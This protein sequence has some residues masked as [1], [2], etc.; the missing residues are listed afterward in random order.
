MAQ[1]AAKTTGGPVPQSL[2]NRP[3]PSRVSMSSD[4]NDFDLIMPDFLPSAREG[5]APPPSK[6]ALKTRMARP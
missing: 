4:V 2:W 1:G 6:P 3:T 5:L